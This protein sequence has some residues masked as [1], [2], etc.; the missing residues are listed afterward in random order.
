MKKKSRCGPVIITGQG[1]LF[2]HE[3]GRILVLEEEQVVKG[4]LQLRDV[5]DQALKIS[6][7]QPDHPLLKSVYDQVPYTYWFD[8]LTPRAGAEVL[9]EYV[10]TTHP[11]GGARL[12]T[13]GIPNRFPFMVLASS[14][15]LRIY[16]AGDASDRDQ[17]DV[18]YQLKGRMQWER[19]GRFKEEKDSQEAFFWSFYLPWIGNVLEH[20]ATRPCVEC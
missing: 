14:E 15:P 1:W 12:K 19:F 10:L 3:D 11:E 18:L 13:M 20:V 17:E 9:A 2:V 8:I 5:P 4:K 6:L 7:T 16:V